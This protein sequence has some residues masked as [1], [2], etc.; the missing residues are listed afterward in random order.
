ME[1]KI[2]VKSLAYFLVFVIVI[3]GAFWLT[4][5]RL[6]KLAGDTNLS[7][8]FALYYFVVALFLGEILPVWIQ[9]FGGVDSHTSGAKSAMFE[10][11]QADLPKILTY[12]VIAVAMYYLFKKLYW[13]YVGLIGVAIGLLVEFLIARPQ[14]ANGPNVVANPIGSIPSLVVVW[15]ILILAPYAIFKLCIWF[16]KIILKK[17]NG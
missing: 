4:K 8:W 13:L 10:N 1:T 6:K 11:W 16:K 3:I 15:F 9:S 14:E 5:K 17:K 12:A 7:W 2:V